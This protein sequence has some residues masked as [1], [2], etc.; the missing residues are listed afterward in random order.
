MSVQVEKLENNMAKLT[1][2]VAAEEFVAATTKAYNKNKNQISVP[3]FRKGKVPQA[4]V[5]KMYGA[6]IFYEEAANYVIPGAY[7]AAAKESGLDITSY[8]EI[9]VVEMEKGK[10][11]IF[12]AT[13][14]LRPEVELG[15]YKGVEIEKVITEVTDEDMEE[16]IKKVQEQNSREVT[17]ERAAENGD[18][19]MID[20]AGSVDGVAFDGGTAEGQALVLGSGTF[21]P[22]FEEQLIGAA[23]GAD[24]DVNVTFPEEYHAKDLAGKAA[25][26]KVKVHEV[27]TKE[28]PEVDDEFAQDISDFETL[29]EYK[30]DLKKR[31][32]ERK[33]ET[34]KAERQQ[35]VMDVVV[36][37]AKMDI[38]EAMVKKSTDDM[39][40]QYAQDLAA[41]GLNMDIYFQYTGMTPQQLAEQMKPQALANIKNRLVLDAIAAAEKIEV[42]DEDIEA[43]I[44]RLADMWKMEA[45]KVRE[46]MDVDLMRKDMAAQKALDMITETA[47][48]K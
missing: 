43:E 5:E 11:F 40:N 4:M 3:G 33:A 26:F 8:P 7:E 16:E 23:A 12:T 14:A 38:P 48:E 42:T 47:V 34:A 41:Q 20:Y 25:L 9:D 15:A 6:S 37:A 28:Y 27:K 35:K 18:T 30:E 45:D 46:Y 24:V 39:M 32:E 10:A 2:E 31:L 13:V 44:K 22:G 29:A 19:V 36:G 21:I 17:V 1:V